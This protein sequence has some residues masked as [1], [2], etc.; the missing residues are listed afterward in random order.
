MLQQ[1]RPSHR[2]R[3]PVLTRRE[4]VAGVSAVTLAGAMSGQTR[5]A[6]P[7]RY[8]V[9]VIGHTGRG[10][11]GHGVD[12]V[13]LEVPRTQVVAVADADARGLAAA[14]KRLGGVKGYADYRKMLDE[15]KPEIVAV[16]PRW[17]G[18]HRDMVVAAAECGARGI[19]MEKPMCPTL[20][21]A[22]ADGRRVREAQGQA[23]HGPPDPLQPQAASD[24]GADRARA[25]WAG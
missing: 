21:E 10:N 18:E 17:L 12:T 7:H 24:R 4:F 25:S 19:Y 14:V 1:H 3:R 16:G 15:V 8:R 2:G 22:D 5:A 9:A 13:W 20:A 23:G 11:Y 6:S